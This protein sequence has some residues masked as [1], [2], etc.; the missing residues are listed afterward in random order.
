MKKSEVQKDRKWALNPE[1]DQDYITAYETDIYKEFN[2]DREIRVIFHE[3]GKQIV[4]GLKLDVQ[5]QPMFYD[6]SFKQFEQEL[7]LCRIN[8]PKMYY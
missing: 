4:C 8:L 6:H 7:T 5:V 3:K 1:E 2:R